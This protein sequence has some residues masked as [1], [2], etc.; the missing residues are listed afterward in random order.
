MY[1]PQVYG[2]ALSLMVLSM[3]LGVVGQYAEALPDLSIS[4][5]LLGL[6]DRAPRRSRRVGADLRK[7]R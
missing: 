6:C 7:L 1:Q 2:I 3:L 4:T 5:V